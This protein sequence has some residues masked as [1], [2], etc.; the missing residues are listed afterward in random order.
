M[1]GSRS[2]P[3]TAY[4]E[5]TAEGGDYELARSD[6]LAQLSENDRLLCVRRTSYE[7]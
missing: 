1:I 5:V 3:E 4:R 2:D 7:N 6:I